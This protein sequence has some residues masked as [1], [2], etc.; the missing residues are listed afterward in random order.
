MNHACVAF[1]IRNMEN[2]HKINGPDVQLMEKSIKLQGQQAN[3]LIIYANWFQFASGE[4]VYHPSVSSRMLLWCQSGKGKVT[5]NKQLVELTPSR[6][7]ILPWGH[8][9]RYQ[10]DFRSP[11]LLAGIHLIPDHLEEQQIDFYVPHSTSDPLAKKKARRDRPEILP[12]HIFVDEW[13]QHTRLKK[14]AEYILLYYVNEE[15]QVTTLRHMGSLFL[16]EIQSVYS[17][18]YLQHEDL[19]K[20]LL[21]MVQYINDHLYQPLNIEDLMIVS[22]RSSATIGRLFRKYYQMSP[23]DFILDRKLE[24]AKELLR[25]SGA[26]VGKIAEQVGFTDPFYFSKVFKK[27]VGKT[28]S[29]F[30]QEAGLL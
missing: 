29:Q 5:V 22:N 10:A 11:F 7:A 15:V 25:T 9:I 30:R 26:K 1:S 23:T 14:L 28:P 21:K 18:G 17:L 16:Q 4:T 2:Y 6:F 3:P 13:K 24:Q 27:K 20:E 19:P 8:S 12:L